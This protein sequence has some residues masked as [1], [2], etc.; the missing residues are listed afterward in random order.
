MR[1]EAGSEKQRV[2][3]VVIQTDATNSKMIK[4]KLIFP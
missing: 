3:E 4:A 2:Q 1:M